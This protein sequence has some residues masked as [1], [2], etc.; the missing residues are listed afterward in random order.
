VAGT[1][2]SVSE[3]SILDTYRGDCA[4]HGPSCLTSFTWRNG[5]SVKHFVARSSTVSLVLAKRCS[6]RSIGHILLAHSS[7]D[8]FGVCFHFVGIVNGAA[9]NIHFEFLCGYLLLV[10]LAINLRMEL[11]DQMVSSMFNFLKNC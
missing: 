5:F 2:L 8:E 11:L 1:N 10:F 9:I 4:T 7:L 3:F 6:I